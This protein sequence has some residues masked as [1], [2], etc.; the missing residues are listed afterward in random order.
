MAQLELPE[1]DTYRRD[2]ERDAVGRKIKAVEVKAMKSL[3]H[4][5]TKKTVSEPLVGAKVVAVDRRGMQLLI[6]LNND[7]TI[8]ISLG[9]TGLLWRGATKEDEADAVQVIVTFTQG[10]DLRMIDADG[11]SSFAVVANDDLAEV[12]VPEEELGL[13]LIVSPV[14][15][16]DFRQIVLTRNEKLKAMLINPDVFVGIG[17]IYSDE[18]LFDAGLKYD[19]ACSSLTTQEVR[20]LYQSVVGIMHDA[21][22]YRGTSLEKRPF[23]D[24]TGAEGEFASHLAVY[25]K[26][27]D[28][29]PRSR[30]PIRKATF[31]KKPVY[32]CDTQV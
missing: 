14:T 30:R 13:D 5:R 16:M 24:L 29:S 17:D 4:H 10:G 3:P 2:L 23:F 7:H 8:V 15:W 20:R 9:E 27:G 6:A 32:F 21:I 1:I 25:G 11:T 18:I 12:L 22:K 26:E 19:R 31:M 28:L